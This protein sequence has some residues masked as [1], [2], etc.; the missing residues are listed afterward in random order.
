M[1]LIGASAVDH[2]EHVKA[3]EKEFGT[4]PI[5]PNPIPLSHK[6]HPKPDF[7][8]LEV[9]VHDDDIPMAHIAVVIK[10]AIWSDSWER[11]MDNLIL[12]AAIWWDEHWVEHLG[13]TEG[14]S[15]GCF[16]QP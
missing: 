15:K 3:V 16:S 13:A 1:I 7:A 4:L 8:G 10:G 9:H 6:A 14:Y 11:N 5:L 12:K 2:G